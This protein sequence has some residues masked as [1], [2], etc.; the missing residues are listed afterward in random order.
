MQYLQILATGCLSAVVV[1]EIVIGHTKITAGKQVIPVSVVLKG[2][3]F[4][5]QPIND[6]TIF[7]DAKF[8]GL[9]LPPS[10][11]SKHYFCFPELFVD[12]FRFVNLSSYIRPPSFGDPEIL[13]Q[14]LDQVRGGRS[15]SIYDKL[16]H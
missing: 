1:F 7:S 16:C 13:T 10:Y 8:Y 4:T 5:Y 15:M 2:A 9:L 11:L 6:M 3:W 12:L 14:T